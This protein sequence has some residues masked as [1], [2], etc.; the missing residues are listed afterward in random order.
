MSAALTIEGE[1]T[2]YTVHALKDRLMTAMA[3]RADLALD[4]RGVSEVDGAG[5]QLL[6]A[7]QRELRQ[8]GGTLTL[9]AC[10]PPLL[11]ALALTDLCDALG[12]SPLLE[13]ESIS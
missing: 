6:L 7:T 4:V 8:R 11:A 9:S 10:P 12:A 3:G 13:T 5:I 2:V 1:L